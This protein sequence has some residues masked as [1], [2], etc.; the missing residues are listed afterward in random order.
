VIGDIIEL[1][2]NKIL[3][4]DIILINGSCIINES[5][6]TGESIPVIKNELPDDDNYYDD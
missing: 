3:P 5:I 6:L 1:S 2:A 4:C